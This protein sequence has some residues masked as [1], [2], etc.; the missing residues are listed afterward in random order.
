MKKWFNLFTK[1]FFFT[2]IGFALVAIGVIRRLNLELPY[3][4]LSAGVL[5]I[6]LLFSLAIL[7]FKSSKGNGVLHAILAFAVI[8]PS[9]FVLRFVFGIA[10][11]R[12]S[13]VIYLLMVL[14]AVLYAIALVVVSRKAKKEANGLNQL[15]NETRKEPE[16]Q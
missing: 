2:A 14:F 7:L 8:L 12:F 15:L 5:I 11:F 10:V 9:V 1:T 13:S 3:L 16:K 6:A 4:R